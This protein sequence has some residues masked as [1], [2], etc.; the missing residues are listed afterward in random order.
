[1]NLREKCT[2]STVFLGV[3]LRETHI[4]CTISNI[5][6]LEVHWKTLPSTKSLENPF[7]WLKMKRV[8]RNKNPQSIEII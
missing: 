4:K 5:L 6:R 1:M 2:P 7:S 3:A 8:L